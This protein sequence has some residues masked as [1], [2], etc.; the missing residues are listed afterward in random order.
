MARTVA[1]R[2]LGAFLLVYGLAAVLTGWWA[3]SVTREAF[4]S[5]RSFSTAF[6]RERNRAMEALQGVTGVLGGREGSGGQSGSALP[7]Q[8]G[9]LAERLRGILGG[10]SSGPTPVP[11]SGQAPVQSSGSFLDDLNSRL[12]QVRGSW[13]VLGE[14]PF[15]PGLLDQ[16]ELAVNLI[17]GWM[18]LH[19]VVSGIIGLRLLLRNPTIV[20]AAAGPTPAAWTPYPPGGYPPPGAPGAPQQYPGYPPYPPG[21]PYPPPYP[22]QG[23][24]P[25]SGWSPEQPTRPG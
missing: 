9:S 12:N 25:E 5:V 18:V 17:L 7:Q 10:Q 16:V 20:V 23:R 11:G 3:Y 24:P 4:V 14:G 8:A 22:P 19:G 13:G 21:A 1:T 6:E 15:R 2:L